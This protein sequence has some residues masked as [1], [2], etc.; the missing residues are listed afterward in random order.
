M[1]G[2]E[3]RDG[4][5]GWDGEELVRRALAAA[6]SPD[7]ARPGAHAGGTESTGG[8]GGTGQAGY[9]VHAGQDWVTVAPAGVP[10]P[11][12][13]WKLHV[14]SRAATF[15]AL[16]A[17]LLPWL[18]AERCHFKLAR[19]EEVLA[20][21]NGGRPA[22][23]GVGKAVTVY[24][25]ASRVRRLGLDLAE[26]T[27]GHAGPRVLSDR[28][29]APDAPVYYRYGPFA[30]RWYAGERGSLAIGVPGPDGAW[31][32]GVATLDYRQPPWARDP[33]GGDAAAEPETLG[34]RYR[35]TRGIYQAAHGNVFRAVDLSRGRG[36]VVKQARAHVAENRAGGDARAR[37]R[38]ERRVLAACRGVPGT[39]AFLDHFAHG[40][41]EFLVTEDV[42]STNLL[43]HVRLHGAL[44]PAALRALAG[45]LAG[46]LAALHRAGVIVRDLTPRNVVLGHGRAHLVDFGLAALDGRYFP[47]GTP[48]FVPPEQLAGRP[49]RPADDCFALGMTLG[50]AATGMTPPAEIPGRDLAA[51][52]MLQS[53][54]ARPPGAARE[55]ALR[56]VGGLLDADPARAAGTL[57]EL[58]LGAWPAGHGAGWAPPPPPAVGPRTAAALRDRVLDLLLTRLAARRTAEAEG[59]ID[60]VDA[61]VYTGSAGIGLELLHHLGHPGVA[62]ALPGLV[63]HARRAAGRVGLAEGLLAGTTGIG[64]FL[65]RAAAAGFPAAPVTPAA[66]P[67]PHDDVFSGTAGVGLGALLL[68][69]VTG[70]PGPLARAVRRAEDLLA[71]EAPR[72]GVTADT[73][74]PPG[75]GVDPTFGYAHGSAGIA[76]F[77]TGLAART[78]DPELTRAALTAA[79]RL[80]ARA[81]ALT[82]AAWR[83]SAVPVTASWC[84]GLAGAV[85]ALRHAS[86][87]LDAPELGRTARAAA[88]ACAAWVPRMENLGQCCGAA[89]V[90]GA[91]LDL[92]ADEGGERWREAAEGVVRH[93]LVRSHGPDEAPA[94]ISLEGQDAPL[95]FGM[96]YAGLLS[97]LRRFDLPGACDPLSPAGRWSPPPPAPPR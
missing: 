83:P 97:F 24:P 29:V 40:E 64:L 87:V 9:A 95:S 21:M 23:A 88:A 68:A 28:R 39:A 72:L 14:S 22:P 60:A 2:W 12:H 4:R 51:R 85:R 84:Q 32:D 54:A 65:A 70:D 61:G 26:L 25:P 77:L 73:G 90:G 62:E 74:L 20:R 36:V 78:G 93:L 37:L 33:F 5:D 16:A 56:A 35:V 53:L 38:N 67:E 7:G 76:D 44:P 92:A 91:L 18:L 86:S 27:R 82:A 58:A 11:A 96:G 48:G 17:R 30:P 1:P 69:D 75:A 50:F 41:D 94:M 80:A 71:R 34:G 59:T 63:A 31:F 49:P 42:G 46:T 52:R 15:P 55:A 66:P 19:S 6:G 45:E 47:G 10:L 57:A 79:R 8:T 13:G 89:G 3:G 43:H 81:E